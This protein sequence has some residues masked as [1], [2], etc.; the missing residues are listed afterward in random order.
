VATV[1]VQ[2]KPH[3]TSR[4]IATHIDGASATAAKATANAVPAKVRTAFDD[5]FRLTRPRPRAAV[6]A[7]TPSAANRI[8]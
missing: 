3:T 5:S 8:P 6:M 4:G 7:P 2:L 1:A